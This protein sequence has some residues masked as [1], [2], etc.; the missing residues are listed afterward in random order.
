MLRNSKI[1]TWLVRFF[2]VRTREVCEQKY[3]CDK[4]LTRI[5]ALNCFP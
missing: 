1:L 2:T 5:L 4:K 3:H